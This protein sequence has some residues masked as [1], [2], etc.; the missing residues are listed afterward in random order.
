MADSGRNWNGSYV[1]FKAP[2][3]G[4]SKPQPGSEGGERAGVGCGS[5]CS[6]QRARLKGLRWV[7]CISIT[8]LPKKPSENRTHLCA[9]FSGSSS[10]W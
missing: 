2:G 5:F 6:G 4:G 1:I 7:V 8:L 9:G 3:L 10:R